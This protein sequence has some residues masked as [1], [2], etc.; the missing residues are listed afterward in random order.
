MPLPEEARYETLHNPHVVGMAGVPDYYSVKLIARA[1]DRH[2]F[3]K[4]RDI[5]PI[6]HAKVPI[7]KFVHGPSGL[8]CDLNVNDSFGLRNSAM[9]KAYADLLPDIVAPFVFCIKKWSS[10]R[11]INDP[12]GQSGAVSFNSYTVCLLALQYLQLRGI[13]PNLQAPTLLKA[14]GTPTERLWQRPSGKSVA[15][16]VANTVEHDESSQSTVQSIPQDPVTGARSFDTSFAKL[17]TAEE[18]T[19]AEQVSRATSIG[20]PF[21]ADGPFTT[22]KD[23]HVVL[24][25]LLVGFFEWIT[26]FDFDM[27]GISLREGHPFRR[28]A[29][30]ADEDEGMT[31]LPF[32]QAWD[33]KWAKHPI[34]CQDPFILDRNTCG[35]ILPPTRTIILDEARRAVNVLTKNDSLSAGE[36]TPPLLSELLIDFEYEQLLEHHQSTLEKWEDE[37]KAQVAQKALQNLQNGRGSGPLGKT[38]TRR[39]PKKAK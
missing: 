35:A 3:G 17:R 19:H 20:Q 13:I 4:F 1:L 39:V 27:W 12:S 14:L 37:R 31:Q 38:P 24:G 6:W 5:V 34:L 16:A 10:K 8:A 22:E 7:V 15:A 23:Q 25:S 30:S 28:M 9:I 26:K 11:H 33:P 21:Q 32:V 36:G 2:G 18:K 29:P